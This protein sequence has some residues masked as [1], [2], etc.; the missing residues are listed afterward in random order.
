MA[1]QGLPQGPLL[2]FYG[3]DFTGASASMEVL[4]FAGL[5]T[6]LFLNPPS[7]E[8]LAAFRSH[9]AIGI[10]GT[11]RS[12]S[13]AWMDEH[14]PPVF[15][16]L[17][18]LGAPV[19]HYKVCSTFDSSPEIG[20]IGRA[21]DIAIGLLRPSWAPMV[22]AD[23][24]MGR[25]QSFGH[26]FAMAGNAGYRLDRHPTMSRHPST[27]MHES[28][29]GRHL[30]RQ[31]D[32]GIGLV[33]FVAMK[34]GGGDQQLEQ[35]LAAGAE[36]VSIDVLD[37]ETLVEAGRLIWERAGRPV[38]GLGSQGFEA[39]LVAYWQTSGSLPAAAQTEPPGGVARM[40]CVSGSVSPATADQ[41]AFALAHGFDGIRLDVARVVDDPAWDAEIGRATQAALDSVGRGRDPLVYTAAG[42]DDPAV[43]VFLETTR[44][45]GLA[46]EMVNER[47]GSGLGR[48]LKSVIQEAGLTRAVISGGDTS[49]RA[50]SMLGIDALTAIAPLDPGSPLCRAHAP[51]GGL[52]GLQIALKG[53]QV[54]RPDFFVAAKQGGRPP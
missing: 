32:R 34:R 49:G 1:A 30:A 19:L 3:D 12:R 46:P 41:V 29:L 35:A 37:R 45:A 17:E 9:R 33:D 8:R 4:A 53:G 31:T 13:P 15:R 42:P 51:N 44:T 21:A 36:I 43:A 48:I 47:L 25:Y 22:V 38:F 20:S 24:G 23:P 14:L 27:P 50:A 39:A 2:A 26:L 54:G 5:P 7:E 52:D 28:D 11:A 16:L 6:V 10:A 18:S 40:A